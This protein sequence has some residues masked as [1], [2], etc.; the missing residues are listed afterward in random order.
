MTDAELLAFAKAPLAETDTLN[1]IVVAIAEIQKRMKV[2]H[3]AIQTLNERKKML[4]PRELRTAP[5]NKP[6]AIA[7][8]K[9]ED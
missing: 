8:D 9:G 4:E 5:Q 1:D 2:W 3:R 7:Y 6:R